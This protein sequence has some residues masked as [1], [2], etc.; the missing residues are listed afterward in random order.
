MNNLEIK[1]DN[2]RIFA[3]GNYPD[4]KSEYYPG[5]IT[6]RGAW[7]RKF[8]VS[9]H[10]RRITTIACVLENAGKKMIVLNFA[11]AKNPGGGYVTGANAQEESLCRCSMLYYTIRECEEYYSANRNHKGADYTDGMIYSSNVPVIRNDS[12]ELL[13]NPVLC[14]FI[15]CPAVNRRAAGAY[16][17]GEKLNAAMERRIDGITALALSKNPDVVVFGA[18]GCGVFGNRRETVYPLFEKAIEKYWDGKAEIIFA[19]PK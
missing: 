12:G 14:D 2:D 18:F 8:K 13:E 10:I 6:E 19:D 16:I 9:E 5:F 17:S 15:T 1:R 3:Q 4:M 7:G 11:S